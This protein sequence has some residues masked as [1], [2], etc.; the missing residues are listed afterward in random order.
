[1]LTPAQHLQK[2]EVTGRK[3]FLFITRIT[4]PN[5]TPNL[6]DYTYFVNFVT[7]R[8]ELITLKITFLQIK[9]RYT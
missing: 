2:H 6:L 8:H 9:K 3:R 1:M 7:N 5:D 4:D